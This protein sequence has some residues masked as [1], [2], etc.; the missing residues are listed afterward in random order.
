MI[1]FPHVV[2]YHLLYLLYLVLGLSSVQGTNTSDTQQKVLE[3]NLKSYV[4]ITF[5]IATLSFPGLIFGSQA[6][7]MA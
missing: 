1:N 3:H 6:V 4:S 2:R 5:T 7:I